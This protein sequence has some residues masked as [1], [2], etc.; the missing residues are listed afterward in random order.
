MSD[1]ASYIEA[2]L[3]K[4]EQRTKKS[5]NVEYEILHNFN[6]TNIKMHTSSKVEMS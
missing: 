6:M 2:S 5:T 3:L 1:K 4:I